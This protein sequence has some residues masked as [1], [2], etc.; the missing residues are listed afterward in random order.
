M[1]VQQTAALAHLWHKLETSMHSLAF[2]CACAG[3]SEVRMLRC[4]LLRSG[5][6]RTHAGWSCIETGHCGDGW[7]LVPEPTPRRLFMAGGHLQEAVGRKALVALLVVS[8]RLTCL[9]RTNTSDTGTSDH[10]VECGLF[11]PQN[12]REL[13]LLMMTSSPPLLAALCPPTQFILGIIQQFTLFSVVAMSV[14]G[15]TFCASSR[16]ISGTLRRNVM[17]VFNFCECP[18]TARCLSAASAAYA[19]D[20]GV[21]CVHLETACVGKERV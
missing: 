8:F 6:K 10:M 21:A 4:Y 14:Y 15:R 9:A 11:C 3:A 12:C 13:A 1:Q 5:K 17:T 2:S 16:K 7:A 20:G 18:R 19:C